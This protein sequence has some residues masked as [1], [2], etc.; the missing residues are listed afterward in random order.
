[1][2]RAAGAV[3][4][5]PERRARGRRDRGARGRRA[6]RGRGASA[7]PPAGPGTE[8]GGARRYEPGDDAR[9]IDWSLTA[10]SLDPHVRTT[11]ADREL[12]TLVVVDRSPSLDFG[13]ARREKRELALATLAAFGVLTGRSG[14]RLGVVVAGGDALAHL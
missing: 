13:T 3:D 5:V 11:E 1:A 4:V 9:R 12:H 7:P 14:N 6:G 8:R 10:R 2:P